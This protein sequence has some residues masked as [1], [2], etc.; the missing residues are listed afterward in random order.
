MNRF[1]ALIDRLTVTADDGMKHRLL[2]DYFSA[3]AEPDCTIA[4]ALLA[5]RR[6]WHRVSLPLIRGLAEAR[7]DATLFELSLAHVG[8]LGETIALLWPARRGANRDPSLAEIAEALSSLGKSELVKRLEAWL[9][10]ADANGRWLLIKLVT[11][12][13]RPPVTAA[14]VG[15]ALAAAG[16]EGEVLGRESAP[17]QQ[18]NELF[19]GADAA[20]I[21]GTI[22]T[23]L[24]YVEFG[25]TRTSPVACTFGMWK[26]DALVPVGKA[27]VDTTA[28]AWRQIESF[29]R[30]NTAARFGPVREVAHTHEQGLVLDIAFQGLR[31]VPRRKSGVALGAAQIERVREGARPSTAQTIEMLANLLHNAGTPCP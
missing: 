21:N 4:A 24:L 5:G 16:I 9:D 13:F 1:A 27:A 31:R 29:V 3:A 19:A 14:Q 7:F 23:V 30:D 22:Q 28:A 2:V 8:D 10:A 18:Q 12:G 26:G 20:P 17:P 11:G 6:K 15:H 25:R